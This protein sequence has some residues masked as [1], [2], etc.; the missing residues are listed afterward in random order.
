MKKN[1][2]LL[3]ILLTSLV[4]SC[5]GDSNNNDNQP[6]EQFSYFPLSQGTFWTY[7]NVSQQTNT[8]DSL[9]VAG[10][11]VVNGNSYTN[12]DAQTPANAFMTQVLSR[13]LIREDN[14]KLIINGEIGGPPVDGFPEITIPLNDVILYDTEADSGSELSQITGEISQEVQG[15]PI[16]IDYI[17]T[18][19]QDQ[20]LGTH[21]VNGIDFT[22]VIS[23]KIIINLTIT[24]SLEINGI[25]LDLPILDPTSQD[26]VV[27][28]NYYAKDIGLIDSNV[29]VEYSLVDLSQTGIDLPIPQE[30]SQTATQKIDTYETAQ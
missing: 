9:Y 28:T 26:I 20:S 30:D 23:S 6:E 27:V 1:T 8:R 15:Y 11:E 13:S 19:Q 10:T 4:I 3:S 5:S 24:L 18:S 2:F 21:T 25:P 17:V 29:L 16:T 7:N 22:D 12:L 14:S